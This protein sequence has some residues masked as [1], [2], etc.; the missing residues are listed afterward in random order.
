MN[1]MVF[2]RTNLP[3]DTDIEEFRWKL[4]V[5]DSLTHALL[6]EAHEP[7]HKAHG[8]IYKTLQSLRTKYYWPNM[9]VQVR[10]FVNNCTR[11]KECKS[12]NQNLMPE[13]GNEVV[14]D[15]PFQKLY[16][17]FLGKYPRSK[18][19]N[20]Y[21][22]IVV[23]HM[24]KFLF[25]KAMREA[26]AKNVIKFLVEQVFHDFGVP[27]VIH[28]DNGKQFTCKEFQKMT[29]DYGINHM[30]TAVHSPQSNAAERVNQSVLAAIRTYLNND[31]REWDLN[32]PS[33][34]V[35]LRTSIHTATGVSPF[36]ALFGHNMFT[37]G[38]DYKLARKLKALDDS[39]IS[40]LDNADRNRLIRENMKERMHKAYERSA[41]RYNKGARII[42]FVPGQEVFKRNFILSDFKNNINAKFCR[43]FTKCR[44]LRALGNNMYELENCSGK[45]IGVY[46]AKDIKQ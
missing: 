31:H 18:K 26:T 23:D 21:I 25:L 37:S 20:A 30:R 24:T 43:K 38:T 9:I 4:W 34:E 44:V 41:L 22:F 1:G 40:I 15:R 6:K 8:G 35:A 33:I 17:D 27:E 10:A 46:H 11:C 3:S 16:I 29:Q 28:S 32:L 12:T 14:T 36:M 5:P 13:I 2:K 7:E 45:P 42:R 39:E 19:G